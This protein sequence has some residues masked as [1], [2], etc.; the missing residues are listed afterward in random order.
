MKAESGMKN[1]WRTVALGDIA[2]IDRLSLQPDDIEA[3]TIYVGLEHIETGGA[4]LDPKPVSAGSLASS[5]FRFTERHILYGKLRPYLAKIACPDFSGI[6]STDILPVLPSDKIER[7]YLFHFLRQPSMVGYA[8]SR[9]VG[10]NLPRLNPATLAEFQI[11]L[12]TVAEQRRIAKVLDRAEMLRVRRRAAL[13]KLD[14]LTQSIFFDF[15]GDPATNPKDWPKIEMER[16]F[17]SPPIFGTMI[18]ASVDGGSWLSL[19]V[20][21]IQ[22]WQLDLRDQKFVELSAT[23][24]ER[25][26]VKDG[27]LLLARAIA[28]QDHLGKAIVVYPN[29]R[30]WAFDSHLMRLRFGDKA[31]PEFIRNLLMTFGGRRLFLKVTRRSAVQFNVNTKEIAALKI[32]LPPMTLQREFALRVAAVEKLKAAHRASLLEMDA[33]FA[34]LQDRAFKG[35]L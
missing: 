1:K 29:G 9:A 10:V 17:S 33:L 8:N 34:S 11:P 18:P 21:N 28:S 35:E 3:G 14:S 5:K 25:H 13:T 19:R 23:T 15:F 7:R 31:E 20:A 30:K 16:L 26:S 6:C 22:D 24:L 2:Q 32:P 4:F 12:P 27:D